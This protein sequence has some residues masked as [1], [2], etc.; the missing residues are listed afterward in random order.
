MLIDPSFRLGLRD[1][2]LILLA[3]AA[4][5]IA[6]GVIALEV[7]LSPSLT[8]LS[9]VVIVSGAAQF[10]MVALLPFG[11]APVLFA[12]SGLG[13]RH[14]PMAVTLADL[15]GSRPL[16][17]RLRLAFVLVDETFGLSLRAAAAGVEDLVAYKSAADLALYTGWVA[18]TTVGVVF[19]GAIDPQAAGVGVLFGLLFL[20]LAAP[21]V[22]RGRDWLVAAASV[23]ATLTAT[24]TLPAAWQ[25]TT[26]A[27]VA[28]LVGLG[29]DE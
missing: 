3:V 1:S 14:L 25:I 17:T 16:R 12:A 27:T 19:G 22:R 15:I 24:T 26:A 18:G 23:A 28:S 5:G 29:F 21:L 4:F 20:G 10:A 2:I 11:A 6:Y 13:L 8:I 9:S 7:G